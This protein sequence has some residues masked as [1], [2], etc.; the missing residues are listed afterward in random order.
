MCFYKITLQKAFKL[1]T[2]KED[3]CNTIQV[4]LRKEKASVAEYLA[5]RAVAGITVI[6]PVIITIVCGIR[7]SQ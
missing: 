1:S 4:Y 3:V 5:S 2:E 6:I 7:T